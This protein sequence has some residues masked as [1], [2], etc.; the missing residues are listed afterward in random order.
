MATAHPAVD[1]DAGWIEVTTVSDC[2]DRAAARW[3]H[4]ALVF[5][6][7]RATYPELS[8][9]ADR[10][11]RGLLACALEPGDKV[12]ILL[13]QGLDYVALLLAVTKAGGVAVP[14]NARYKARELAHVVTSSDMRLLFVSG[15]A[16]VVDHLALLSEALPS[17]TTAER[18]QLTLDEAP[19][20][21]HLFIFGGDEAP[22]AGSR[23]SFVAGADDVAPAQV[24]A[25]RLAVRVRDTAVIMYTSGTTA[26]PK[27]A[28]LSHEAL[29]REGLMVART[30][31]HLGPDDRVWTALP[32]Y[33]IGG[34]AF[35]FACWAAGATYCHSGPFVP[36]V[37]VQQLQDERC[38]VAI[39]AFETIWLAVLE[40]PAFGSLDL[41]HLRLVFN[42]GVPSRLRHMQERVPG[43]VQV[44]GFG[45]TE[46]C[47]FLTLG[48]ADDS[49]EQRVTTC[50]L[51]MP[52]MRI[53]IVNPANGAEVPTG[54]LG[55]ITY[56]G[57]AAFDGYYGDPVQTAQAIDGEGWFH[58]GDMGTV[59]DDDRLTFVTRLKDMM[60]VGGENVAAAEVES[61]LLGHPA[62][63]MAQVVGA[64]DARYTEVPAA[65]LQLRDGASIDVDDVIDFCL[66]AIATYK[67]P[68]YVR[69]VDEWPMSGTKIKKFELRAR[70]AAELAAA[71]ITEAPKPTTA[72]TPA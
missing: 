61:H 41:S 66:G 2:V 62:V 49:L 5:P 28:M 11:A 31:F 1:A 56:R 47:S 71:G 9:L 27:G 65:F 20:L 6:T 52:G 42:V 34:V 10:F 57:W 54:E 33:H 40:H 35:A 72:P 39:P 68:R 50:G 13:D 67:V 37:A 22:W 63:V 25:R 69:V 26:Y 36:D 70:I 43:A 18:A 45:S 15:G 30:R 32:L 53:R 29:V 48:L 38:T 60:K 59:D 17:L 24:Q 51:P 55:E 23:E 7:E 64:P 44:S 3:Q 16:G 19:E 8:R 21:R 58:S 12:G 14:V 46:A 4:D